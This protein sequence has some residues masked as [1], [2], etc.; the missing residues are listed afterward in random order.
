[1]K[2]SYNNTVPE[3]YPHRVLECQDPSKYRGELGIQC[4]NVQVNTDKVFIVNGHIEKGDGN[5]IGEFNPKRL[6][7]IGVVIGNYPASNQDVQQ[8]SVLGVN[9]I[10]DIQTQADRNQRGLSDFTQRSNLYRQN[11]I[12]QLANSSVMDADEEDY[13]DDLFNAACA[14]NNMVEKGYTVYV[15]D[16]N[17]V[18]R[19]S[20]LILIYIAL[21]L[22][23]KQWNN[24][25]AL[26]QYLK[27]QY[28]QG[29]PNMEMVNQ[30]IEDNKDFQQQQLK[31]WRDAEERRKRQAE[32]ADKNKKNQ[33][34]M[35][36]AQR[37]KLLQL[38]EIEKEKLRKQRLKFEEDERL[39]LQKV[40]D[41]DAEAER[42]RR[43]MNDRYR[44]EYQR[45][46]DEEAERLRR[47]K[48]AD[49]DAKRKNDAKAQRQNDEI[50]ALRRKLRELQNESEL[51]S[52]AIR[53]F[54]AEQD[55]EDR[56]WRL[57]L[58]ED[59]KERLRLEQIEIEEIERIRIL[60]YNEQDEFDRLRL[61]KCA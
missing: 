39:R 14:M 32:E 35:D 49:E 57:K 30:V 46:Q 27:V 43:M 4:H 36:D 52:Q 50:E 16:T 58:E 8:L 38:A 11:G 51:T 1:V 55:E 47:K 28:P 29:H 59:E 48:L 37:L 7:D 25:P 20:T 42:K 15:H 10:L 9:S 40:A 44:L 19:V 60:R 41:A 23:H 26:Q 22:R 5:F 34:K 12:N 6:S 33:A 18:S 61:I 31:K 54:R 24:I 53:N 17:G 45:L 2:N 21:F 56:Q 3:R 13:G